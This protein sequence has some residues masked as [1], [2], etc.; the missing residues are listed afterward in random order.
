MVIPALSVS[1]L[2]FE[3]TVAVLGIQLKGV[4]VAPSAY[5]TA[6]HKPPPPPPVFG[7]PEVGDL[8]PLPPPP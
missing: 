6:V 8:P 2:K 4:G 5:L 1:K 3:S 7:K